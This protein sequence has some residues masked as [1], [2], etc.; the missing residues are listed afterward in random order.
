[1]FSMG[2]QPSALSMLLVYTNHNGRKAAAAAAVPARRVLVRS[3]KEVYSVSLQ[4]KAM[5][6]YEYK[7][8]SGCCMPNPTY[9][10]IMR[11]TNEGKYRGGEGTSDTCGRGL[12][13]KVAERK[14]EASYVS[15]VSTQGTTAAVPEG[16]IKQ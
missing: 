2:K 1:M 11:H 3:R 14:A 12:R 7:T 13:E 16:S 4:N 9:H 10:T 6:L 8:S 5:K 15:Y